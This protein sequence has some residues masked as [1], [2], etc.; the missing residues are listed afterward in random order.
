MER[1]ALAPESSKFVTYLAAMGCYVWG[2]MLCPLIMIRDPPP[3][4]TN[5][6]QACQRTIFTPRKHRVAQPCKWLHRA[7]SPPQACPMPHRAG[8][9]LAPRPA[10][11]AFFLVAD[12]ASSSES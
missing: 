10:A 9:E 7:R 5:A 4:P 1:H 6:L 12:I 11:M 2:T 8:F 3:P